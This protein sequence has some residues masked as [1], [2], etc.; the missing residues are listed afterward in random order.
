MT[1]L[2]TH[3]QKMIKEKEEKEKSDSASATQRIERFIEK[4]LRE[5]VQALEAK[6]DQQKQEIF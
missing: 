6:C 2:N 3:N 1:S 5:E 4:T